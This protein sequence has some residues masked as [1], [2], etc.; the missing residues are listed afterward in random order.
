MVVLVCSQLAMV[1]HQICA[2]EATPEAAA[3]LGASQCAYILRI[4][5]GN[6]NQ[7]VCAA[8][9]G[10]AAA[11]PSSASAQLPTAWMQP[12]GFVS[13]SSQCRSLPV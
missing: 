5:I 8:L 12:G 9:T 6:L 13:T 7:L 2:V 4:L 1:R 3:V 11:A 10:I